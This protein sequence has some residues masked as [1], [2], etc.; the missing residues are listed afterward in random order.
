[1]RYFVR[2]AKGYHFRWPRRLDLG[3]FLRFQKKALWD[4]APLVRKLLL[5][6]GWL[7]IPLTVFAVPPTLPRRS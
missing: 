1:V 7:G 2:D 5:V 4:L 6:L 3:E